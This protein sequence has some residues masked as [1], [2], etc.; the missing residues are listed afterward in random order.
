MGKEKKIISVR[1]RDNLSEFGSEVFFTDGYVLFCWVC[2][3]KIYSVK[4]F[5]VSQHVRTNKLAK[6][7]KRQTDQ[8]QRKSQLLTNKPTKSGFNKNLFEA[9]VTLNITLKKL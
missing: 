2:K 3:K 8:V 4:K 7:S 5:N 1:L 6:S 9:M